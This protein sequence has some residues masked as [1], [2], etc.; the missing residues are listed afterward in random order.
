MR[1]M[2]QYGIVFLSIVA[3]SGKN[4]FSFKRYDETAPTVRRSSAM[5]PNE[6]VR[7]QFEINDAGERRLYEAVGFGAHPAIISIDLA[8]TEN[9]GAIGGE[10]EEFLW[11]HRDQLPQEL[12]RFW[13]LTNKH[14]AGPHRRGVQQFGWYG[15]EWRRRWAWFSGRRSEYSLVLRRL[16]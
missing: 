2:L 3:F 14:Y 5:S 13:L 11:K 1:H 12:K 4:L 16:V 10:D 8:S 15:K 9:G 7:I 6:T